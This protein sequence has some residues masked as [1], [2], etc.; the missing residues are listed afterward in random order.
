MKKISLIVV[1]I[2]GVLLSVSASD[3]IEILKSRLR[4]EYITGSDTTGISELISGQKLQGAWKDVNYSDHSDAVWEPQVHVGRLREM[5]AVYASGRLP[6][7][8]NQVLIQRII[9][10]LNYWY[11]VN[12]R[13]HNWWY[14]DIGK[15][16]SLAPL[17]IMLEKQLPDELMEEIISDLADSFGKYT[18]QNKL[19]FS[20][21]I[22]WRGMPE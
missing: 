13:S 7:P 1:L 22:V 5:A 12:P 18:G 9:N 4:K 2:L 14:N 10:G 3:D 19:W 11:K 17:A 8:E 15:Q 6:D 20:E 21:Q 16:L